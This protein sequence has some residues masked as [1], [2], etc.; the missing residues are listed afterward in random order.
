MRNA[1]N[2]DTR[3]QEEKCASLN[4]GDREQKRKKQVLGQMSDVETGPIELIFAK[5]RL[6]LDVS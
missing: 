4:G 6:L 2:S 1:K 5:M 3:S